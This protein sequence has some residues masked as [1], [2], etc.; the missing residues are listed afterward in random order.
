MWSL[1]LDLIVLVA[2]CRIKGR[3]DK[4][5]GWGRRENSGTDCAAMSPHGT[6]APSIS[7]VSRRLIASVRRAAL[8]GGLG[9]LCFRFTFLLASAPICFFTNQHSGLLRTAGRYIKDTAMQLQMAHPVV[10]E[11]PFVDLTSTPGSHPNAAE[12]ANQPGAA[13]SEQ[14]LIL[15]AVMPTE[16]ACAELALGLGDAGYSLCTAWTTHKA[17]ELAEQ[18]PIDVVILDLDGRYEVG[19]NSTVVS[20]FRLLHL[21]WRLT[22]GRPVA[23]VVISALDYAEVEGAVRER[24]DDFINKPV[25]GMQLLSRLRGALSRVRARHQQGMTG[26][27]YHHQAAGW[28][29]G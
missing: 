18:S 21:L 20:G 6:L 5:D 15:L 9:W 25:G 3:L 4:R 7:I 28:A 27:T 1:A 12:Q 17:L 11:Q 23:L 8:P 22:R 16:A 10:G 29:P 13:W 26:V 2:V 14:R 24:A 19:G